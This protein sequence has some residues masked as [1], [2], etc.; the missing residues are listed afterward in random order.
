MERTTDCLHSSDWTGKSCSQT[1]ITVHSGIAKLFPSSFVNLT[2]YEIS[3][4]CIRVAKCRYLN[5]FSFYF[6]IN[7]H[8]TYPNPIH[9]RQIFTAL[10]NMIAVSPR[11]TPYI[12]ITAATQRPNTC[13][14]ILLFL[15]I[16]IILYMLFVFF[17]YHKRLLHCPYNNLLYHKNVL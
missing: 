7:L 8:I 2:W 6:L 15:L 9:S 11:L 5:N 4:I 13:T 17:Y 1:G 14:A 10:L 12:I 3:N 16:Q